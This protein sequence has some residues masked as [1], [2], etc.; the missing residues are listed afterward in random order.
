MHFRGAGQVD[1]PDVFTIMQ[2]SHVSRRDLALWTKH[3]TDVLDHTLFRRTKFTRGR[4]DAVDD[5]LL[6]G[7]DEAF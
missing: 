6:A 4:L 3:R 1:D 5:A 7:R 2:H